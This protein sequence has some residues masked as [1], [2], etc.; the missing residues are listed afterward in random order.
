MNS[1]LAI[2]RALDELE[3]AIADLQLDLAAR[4][5]ERALLE[6]RYI[7]DQPRVPAGNPDGGQWTSEGS[8]PSTGRLPAG[9]QRVA[10]AMGRR[11]FSGYLER[12][13]YLSREDVFECTYF[14]SRQNYRFTERWNAPCPAIRLYY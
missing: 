4:N 14:D 11:A 13:N 1:N 5:L 2:K 9:T 10:Q 8:L 3:Y 7:P 6:L 12:Q